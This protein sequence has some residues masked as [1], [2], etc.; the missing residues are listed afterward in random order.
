MKRGYAGVGLY[1]PKTTAN[2]GSAL[3]GCAVYSAAMLAVQGRRYKKSPTDTMAAYRHMPFLQVESLRSVIPYSCTPV[4]VDLIPGA[5]SLPEYKHPENAFYI[6][7]PEDG[8]LGKDVTSWCK[9]VVYVPTTHCMN[10]ACC[11]N[12][13]LYDRMCKQ[14]INAL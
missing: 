5:I 14:E 12:V 2:I 3:R 11:V 6:F 9:D 1:M 10:L 8:T 13:V 4:A 7:G